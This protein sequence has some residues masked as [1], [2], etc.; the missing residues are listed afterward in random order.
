MDWDGL[1]TAWVEAGFE[2]A[3]FW[4]ISL[5]EA[6]REMRGAVNRW[7]REAN[8]RVA[9][10]WNIVALDRTKKLPKLES[11][12][13]K[14]SHTRRKKSPEELLAAMKSIFLAF[15]GNPEEL[16]ETQ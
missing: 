5:A 10:A 7:R 4:D 15:G 13:A 16:R 8:E 12:M 1:H 9:L 2:P 11:L 14:A 3:R 6:D